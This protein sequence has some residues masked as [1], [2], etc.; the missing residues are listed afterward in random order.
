MPNCLDNRI[1]IHTA[2]YIS[3]PSSR[4]QM[5]T[6]SLVRSC[7]FETQF[8]SICIQLTESLSA[9]I[10]VSRSTNMPLYPSLITSRIP[11]TGVA[12]TATPERALQARSWGNLQ[13]ATADTTRPQ[14][15]ATFLLGRIHI[16]QEG[17]GLRIFSSCPFTTSGVRSRLQR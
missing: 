12:I 17:N 4:S 16:A 9:M 11:P 5:R 3:W 2:P 10:P 8:L 7:A 15:E 1:G 13:R 6:R 14:L